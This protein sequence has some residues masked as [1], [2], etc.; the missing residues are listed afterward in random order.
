MAWFATTQVKPDVPSNCRRED[1][2]LHM[3]NG[4]QILNLA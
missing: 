4:Y 2:N 3:V 1:S